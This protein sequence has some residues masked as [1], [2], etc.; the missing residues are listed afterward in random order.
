MVEVFKGVDKKKTYYAV[1]TFDPDICEIMKQVARY[2][3]TTLASIK[4]YKA[5]PG[6]MAYLPD[7]RK[8]IWW[9]GDMRGDPCIVVYK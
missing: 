1:Q 4:D 3:K 2:K 8:A 6:V 7:G 5:R 9:K